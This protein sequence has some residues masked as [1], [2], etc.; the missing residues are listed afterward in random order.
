MKY[1]KAAFIIGSIIFV[2]CNSNKNPYENNLGIEPTVIAQMDTANYTQILWLDTVKN[3]GTI[4]TTDTARIE[5][6]FKNIGTKPLFIIAVQPACGCT[7]ADYSKEPIQPGKEGVVNAMYIWNGQMGALR[8]TIAVRT[9]TKNGRSHTVAF[10]GE[11]VKDS[12]SKK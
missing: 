11:V 6:K 7:V 2:S 5:F 9:N 10:F 4:K 1:I 12:V 3:I 8:K